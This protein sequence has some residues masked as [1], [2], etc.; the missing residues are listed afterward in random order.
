MKFTLLSFIF[1]ISINTKAQK[2]VLLDQHLA[3]PVR[4]TDKVTSNDKFNDFFPVEKKSLPEFINTLQEIEN[5][6]SSKE[7]VGKAKQYQLGCVKFSGVTRSPAKEE[8]L[9]YVLSS[10]CDNVDISMHLC[11]AKFSNASNMYFIKTWLK[12]IQSSV[13]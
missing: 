4:Y 6:L 7:R 12:Y 5:E 13:K 8:R 9:D 1:L 10:S 2:Y 11:D 3:Q